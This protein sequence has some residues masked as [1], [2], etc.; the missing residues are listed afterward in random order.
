MEIL[1]F[2]VVMILVIAVVFV[3]HKRDK[4]KVKKQEESDLLAEKIK[5]WELST[6]NPGGPNFDQAAYDAWLQNPYKEG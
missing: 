6:I 4:D 3:V 2:G 5:E 1:T